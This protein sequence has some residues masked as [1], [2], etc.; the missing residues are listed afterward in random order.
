M[1]IYVLKNERFR[2]SKE[3]DKK[4][5]TYILI[6]ASLFGIYIPLAKLLVRDIPP[7]V[8]VGL[9]YSGS[10]LGLSL[11]SALIR[12]VSTKNTQSANLNK[13]DFRWLFG[14]VLSGGIIAPISMMYGLSQTSG[15]T[16]SL[17]MNLEGAFAGVIAVFFFK[18]QAGRRLW[19][20]LLCM[21]AAGVFL[22]WD[23]SQGQFNVLGSLLVV[24]A[25]LCWGI[26]DNLTRNISARNPIQINRIRGFVA[27]LIYILLAYILGM[28]IKWDFNVLYALLLG[29][30]TSGMGF[31]FFIKALEG[32]GT[33]RAGM[34]FSLAPFIGAVT[35]L[36]LLQECIGWA[37]FPGIV[38]MLAGVWLISNE[39]HSHPHLHP[40][41]VH[42]HL[43][44][45]NDMHHIHD[46][47]GII[48]EPHVHEHKHLKQHHDHP[49]WPDTH[50]RHLH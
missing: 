8:L 48:Q 25:M 19:L 43:H 11:Y 16:A 50:H 26:D 10:F 28:N 23:S 24:L 12:I 33:F 21:T 32:L 36:L 42:T 38:L 22:T 20:A 39:K 27:G 49:H 29:C 40:E 3:L 17:L 46:H 45:H 1:H 18:E 34:L 4:P 5:L 44:Y 2:K 14:A 47:E 15:F 37:M 35:S 9:L 31:V 41:E 6:A 30:F 13:E 7:V